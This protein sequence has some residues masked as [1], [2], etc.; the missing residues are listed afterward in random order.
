[1]L[2]LNT[3][4]GTTWLGH[5]QQ[6]KLLPCTKPSSS[7]GAGSRCRGRRRAA[8]RPYPWAFRNTLSAHTDS[9]APELRCMRQ[10]FS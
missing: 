1:M 9:R 8:V 6:P 5:A 10:A 3:E 2:A 7:Q 4:P